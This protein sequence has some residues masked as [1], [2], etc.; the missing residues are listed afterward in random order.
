MIVRATERDHLFSHV[1]CVLSSQGTTDDVRFFFL[2]SSAIPVL[3]VFQFL[4]LGSLCLMREILNEY[5]ITDTEKYRTTA[6]QKC[7]FFWTIS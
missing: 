1:K 3:K 7:S 4:K 5:I 6:E 2:F